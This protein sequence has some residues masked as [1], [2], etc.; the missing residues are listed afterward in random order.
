[1]AMF[2]KWMN[3]IYIMSNPCY[4]VSLATTSENTLKSKIVKIGST[5]CLPARYV[6]YK[7]YT[8]I[9]I[10]CIRYYHI[11][12][13]DCYK[14]DDDIKYDLDTYRI[15][16][17]GGIEFYNDN[18][19]LVLEDYLNKREIIYTRY[20]SIDDLPEY[21]PFDKSF[22]TQVLADD[23]AKYKVFEQSSNSRKQRQ[24]QISDYLNEHQEM[25]LNKC[26]EHYTLNDKG[27]LNLFCRYGKTRLSS[28]FVLKCKFAKILVLVPSLYLVEQTFQTWKVFFLEDEIFLISSTTITGF[29]KLEQIEKANTNVNTKLNRMVVICTYQSS[30]KLKDY[31]FDVCI[32]DEAHRTTG[33]ISTFNKLITS[34]NITKKL[35][36]TAT[37]KFYD[38]NDSDS[39]TLIINSMD[40][41]AL[42]GE[43]IQTVSATKALA[44]KRIC[45]YSIVTMKLDENKLSSKSDVIMIDKII[46]KYLLDRYDKD[47]LID[48]NQ[49]NIS[50]KVIEFIKDNKSRYMRIA[51]G[52]LDVIKKYKIKHIITFHRYVKCAEVFKLILQQ[53]ITIKSNQYNID[54]ITGNDNKSERKQIIERFENIKID[55]ETKQSKIINPL[56]ECSILCSAKVLQEGVDIP[57]CDAVC[58]VDLKSSAVD[59]I[60]SLSRCLTF[61]QG[62][63][64][65]V[66]IPYDEN[67]FKYDSSNG[68]STMFEE[69]K[70]SSYAMN[71]RLILRNLIEIDD[72]VKEF[73]RKLILNKQNGIS[74]RDVTQDQLLDNELVKCLIDDHVI[75]EMSEIIFDVFSVAKAKLANMGDKK[76]NTPEEYAKSVIKDFNNELPLEPDKV[77][78]KWGWHGWNDYLGIDPYMTVTQVKKHIYSVNL[79]RQDKNLPIIETETQYKEYARDNNLMVQVK[80]KNGN[81]C[82]LLLPN[83]DSLVQQYYTSKEDIIL[84]IQKLG[85]KSI[86]DYEQKSMLDKS[87]APYKYLRNGFYN[88]NIPSIQSNVAK[89]IESCNIIEECIF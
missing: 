34:S 21:K 33:E 49:N 7:T 45:P 75:E 14:L 72:N 24:L 43:V 22:L 54:V 85:I 77:Y 60:Q 83:Y 50:N 5:K 31:K 25:V 56:I 23:I 87:L 16:S 4:N 66:I 40:N 26:I 89:F 76:Y 70:V 82:W 88:D 12:N 44:L 29:E 3:T 18:I 39:D 74:N 79:A 80:P 37:M 52:L 58:F 30:D 62:K 81:W 38:Y 27:I 9:N 35:F 8:P 69:M 32:Y 42:Y 20:E 46:D 59:T 86:S 10:T 2:E 19:L 48:D 6:S 51:I 78:R 28:I 11:L 47:N 53:V 57:S 13:Y 68:D 36:L 63:Q 64:A 71:L 65:F 55:I 84:A 15:H 67:D 73:F 41:K 1:M 61:Q 17:S